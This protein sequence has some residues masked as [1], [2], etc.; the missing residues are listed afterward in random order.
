MKATHKQNISLPFVLHF[1]EDLDSGLYQK[2]HLDS[3]RLND[4][5]DPHSQTSSIPIYAGT[6]LTYRGTGVFGGDTEQCDT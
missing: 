3:Q 1:V 6:S 2:A 4:S 5:Y